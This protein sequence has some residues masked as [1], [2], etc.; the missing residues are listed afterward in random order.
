M[1]KH[2]RLC[3]NIIGYVILFLFAIGSLAVNMP[4][5]DAKEYPSRSIELV[6]PWNPGGRTD[7]LARLVAQG[8]SKKLGQSVVV[9]NKPG[10]IGSVGTKYVQSRKPD[11]YTMGMLA[12]TLI[13]T[14]YSIPATPPV[15]MMGYEWVAMINNDPAILSCYYKLSFKTAADVVDFAKK[16]P[17][18]LK[19]N[20]S[21]VGG[22]QHRFAA[23]F[24]NATGTEFTYVPYNGDAPSVTA[25]AGG[26]GDINF[27]SYIAIKAMLEAGKFRALGVAAEERSSLYPHIPTFKEQGIN[28]EVATWEGLGVPRGTPR[29]V[30]TKIDEALRFALEDETLKKRLMN[31]GI[32]I[33]Y[34]PYK[35][36]S[37]YALNE[38]KKIESFMNKLGLNINK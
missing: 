32:N 20:T 28:C 13:V 8:M 27:V 6:V 33:Q 31:A 19:C 24:A 35:E 21:G 3:F 22:S 16:N 26:H 25:L 4:I 38:D 30:I 5:A 14:Q 9:I 37:R 1:R 34:M 11:G 18:K 12:T 10:G 7:L 15:D 23:T 36:F 2:A 29:S 17:R